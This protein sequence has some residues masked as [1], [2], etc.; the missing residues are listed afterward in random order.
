M[1]LSETIFVVAVIVYACVAI[2]TYF[3]SRI[4]ASLGLAF[5]LFNILS[6]VISSPAMAIWLVLWLPLCIGALA[7]VRG[8]FA[9]ARLAAQEKNEFAPTPG[10]SAP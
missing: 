3:N 6:A 7:G 9:R 2:G 10:R 8:T 5:L 4:A 1:L